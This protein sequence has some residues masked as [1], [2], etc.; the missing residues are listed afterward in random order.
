MCV[1]FCLS[2]LSGL[3][4]ISLRLCYSVVLSV[5]FVVCGCYGLRLIVMIIMLLN[6]GVVFMNMSIELL[7]VLMNVSL[8][9][10]CSVG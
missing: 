8:R 7:F 1:V 3:L 2:V 6:V 10:V 9:C 5:K 4:L